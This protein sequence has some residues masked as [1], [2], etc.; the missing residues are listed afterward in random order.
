MPLTLPFPV[1]VIP[2]YLDLLGV[3]VFGPS[4]FSVILSVSTYSDTVPINTLHDQRPFG[5]KF[6]KGP[7]KLAILIFCFYFTIFVGMV[8]N[9]GSVLLSFR[10]QP[11]L[12]QHA[13]LR[14]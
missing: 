12:D 2:L 3:S 6:S 9:P 13:G 14:V 10:K 11:F 8:Y 1:G 5:I 4:S 7:I